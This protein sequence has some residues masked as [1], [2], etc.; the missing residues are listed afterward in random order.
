MK[1][2]SINNYNGW[3]ISDGDYIRQKD[4][5]ALHVEKIMKIRRITERTIVALGSLSILG[6][7]I[8]VFVAI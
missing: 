3:T 4:E 2:F 1:E 8:M 6:A 5:T 7:L